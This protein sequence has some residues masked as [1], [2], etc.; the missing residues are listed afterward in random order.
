MPTLSIPFDQSLHELEFPSQNLAQVL[1]P[2]QTSALED[3][4][5]GI[6][7]ALD[8]PIGQAPLGDWISPSSRV[9]IVSD[10]NT[11]LTPVAAILP[12]LLHRLNRAGV[13]DERI[14]CIM[15]LGTHRYMTD[16]EM[17]AKVG[18]EVADRIRVF[19]HEWQD[20]S[21]LVD[22]GTSA[23]GTP[24]QVNRAA[25]DADVVIGLGAIVPHHIPGY[26]GSSKIIQPGICGALTTAHTHMLS[27]QS[28][29]DSYL[30]I[31][32]NPVRRD[33][34]DMADK[35]GMETIFNV[36]MNHSGGVVGAF[37]G[38]K[39]AVFRE[40]VKLA[41]AIYGV[42]CE[43]VPDVVLSNSYPCDLD[44]WQSHK[45]LYPAQRMVRPGGSIIICTPAPEGVSPV[46]KDLLT[47]TSWSSEEIRA[48]HRDGRIRNGV[49]AAL[50][51]A[52][53]MVREKAQVIMFSPGIPPDHKEKLGFLHADS[54]AD[55]LT[56]AL[57]EQGPQAR[58]SVLTHAPDL[59]PLMSDGG[60]NA[61]TGE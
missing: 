21:T 20:P 42:A 9:L 50:A 38:E 7:Q 39:R 2:K 34:D 49:A 12:P 15:A 47:F 23:Y 14:S 60:D 13:K 22:L 18:A 32:D 55:A 27:C 48:G 37:F 43:E 54:M 3:L 28:G 45:A 56:K 46:H 31:E 52:W 26:S 44:F 59:L 58:V 30:G 35:V 1:S 41:R 53:A 5:A 29:G 10:D 40:G 16:E 17:V 6:E 8:Q 11:R 36:V 57:N 25:V 51:I 24:L 61:G 4:E 19:N 33:L